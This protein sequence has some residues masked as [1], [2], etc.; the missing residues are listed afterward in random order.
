MEA[1]LAELAGIADP[2]A[3]ALMNRA[4]EASDLLTNAVA[5][6]REVH[7]CVIASAPCCTIS[8]STVTIL[9]L[10][11]GVS[12]SEL[13]G[14]AFMLKACEQML[15]ATTFHHDCAAFGSCQIE[16]STRGRAGC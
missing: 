9:M 8:A 10:L 15:P 4:L 1:A 2:A 13:M 3:E 11:C 6:Q 7:Q 14:Q 5:M 16:L 12:T